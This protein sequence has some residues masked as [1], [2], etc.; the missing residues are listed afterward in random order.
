MP[1]V[2][3]ANIAIK[4]RRKLMKMAKGFRGA[5]SRRVN[6]A[7]EAVL[8]SMAYMYRDRRS[9]KRDLRSLWIARIN[10]AARINGL[11]YSKFMCGLKQAGIEVNRKIL[12]DMALADAPAFAQFTELAR[13]SL[14]AVAS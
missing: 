1:R 6:C 13:K 9:K 3:R 7:N 4:K 8:H 2:K 14:S 11:S 10:A 5:R 12:A